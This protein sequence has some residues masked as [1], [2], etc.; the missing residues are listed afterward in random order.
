MMKNFSRYLILSVVMALVLQTGCAKQ[1]KV[2][3]KETEKAQVA[4]AGA[5]D[6]KAGAAE[7]EVRE[8]EKINVPEPMDL[9]EDERY[10]INI[11][12]SN[13]SEQ[14][15]NIYNEL[16]Q[17]MI[18]KPFRVHDAE[19]D[20]LVQFAFNMY[21]INIHNELTIM[22]NGNVQALTF[23]QVSEKV[24]R[25]FALALTPED[26]AGCGYD[27]SGNYVC[28]PYAIGESHPEFTIINEMI[29]NGDGTYS[30]RFKIYV[31][32]ESATGG[33]MVEDKSVYS[34]TD[35]QA[36]AR[37]GVTYDS[38]GTALVQAY[39]A[40]GKNSYQLISYCLEGQE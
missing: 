40:N 1:D 15:F 26:V 35:D 33:N 25:Y 28:K 21:G 9:T 6:T 37:N 30:V 19:V 39:Q 8:T 11:F 13:F 36:R 24:N 27:I 31:L 16:S 22:D 17:E 34:M 2:I 18:T 10:E 29:D 38:Q 4:E 20:Q 14:G 23:D 32:E 12:L 3:S 7:T 5:I